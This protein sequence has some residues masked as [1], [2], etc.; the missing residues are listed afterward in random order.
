MQS[1]EA[2]DC[3]WITITMDNGVV[4]TIGAG[5]ILPPAYPNFSSTWIEFV[6]TEGALMVDDSHRDVVLSTMD[7]GLVNPMS[8]MPGEKVEHVYAGPMHTE[9]LH[10]LEAVALDRPVLVTPEQARRVMEVYT[11]ADLS[12]ER[13]EPVRLPLQEPP[14]VVV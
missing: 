9:T 10:F 12:A 5:W 14:E 7:K 8:R 11:A 3:M 4:F 13:N 6:G 2:A 1:Y